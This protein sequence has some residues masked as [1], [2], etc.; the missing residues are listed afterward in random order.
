M[1]TNRSTWTVLNI[2][3]TTI[4]YF[5]KNSFEQPR[6]NAERLL[7]HVLNLDRVNMYLQFERILSP[8]EVDTYRGL[9]KR[10]SNHEPLQYIT[11][12]T[13]FMGL[14]MKVNP[15]VLIPR[16]ET[17]VLVENV[18]ALKD[19]LNNHQVHIWDIGTGSGSIGI[20]LAHYWPECQVLATDISES[21]LEVAQNNAHLNE[22][23]NI[24]FKKHDILSE[25]HHW[26]H[27]IDIIISN[28]PY[29]SESE[30]LNLAKEIV[31]YEPSLALTDTKDGLEFYRK[32]LTLIENVNG[33]K[34]IFLEMSGTQTKNILSL[35]NS[36]VL[37]TEVI[38]D[39]NQI[40]RVL[41]IS[42]G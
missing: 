13:E 28:P 33:C 2:L 20:S 24:E 9:V 12:E 25:F 19:E 14:P 18:L 23:N 40:P 21:A 36:D 15:D 27:P 16:P 22:V 3:N 29:I 8:D 37:N 39:L 31:D 1:T 26:D 7:A 5:N 32:I 42:A 10:R 38:S 35:A 11:G 30:Y 41:K 6:L 34:F 4:E 17:E